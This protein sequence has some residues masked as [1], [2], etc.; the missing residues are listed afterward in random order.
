[1]SGNFHSCRFRARTKG[2][3][4]LGGNRLGVHAGGGRAMSGGHARPCA[5]VRDQKPCFQHLGEGSH[6]VP[7]WCR[8]VGVPPRC[9]MARSVAVLKL[10]PRV[11]NVI[12]FAQSVASALTNNPQLPSPT[13]TLATFL[14]DVAALNTAET[15]VLSRTKGAAKLGTRSSRSCRSISR[16]SKRTCRAWRGGDAGECGCDHREREDDRPQGHPARQAGPGGQAGVG[17]RAPSTSR[18]RRREEGGVQLAVLDR[19]EDLDHRPG[20]RSRRRRGS[21]G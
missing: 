21:P 6:S 9:P 20:R 11:K 18:R 16:T 19:P 2:P 1:M 3:R 14:A 17:E 5:T 4:A 15:A 10:S 8:A 12:T 7:A 13:P